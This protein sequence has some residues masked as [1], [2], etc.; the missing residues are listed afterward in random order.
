[1]QP[2]HLDRLTT[3]A[4]DLPTV[5]FATVSGAHL[6]GF[7]SPDSDVDL[8]AAFV[9][10]L[11]TRLGLRQPRETIDRTS[12][13]DG[14]ELDLV[15]HD[16]RKCVRLAVGGSGEVHEHILSPL[17]VVTTPWHDEL[18]ALVR[19]CASLALHRHYR[20][21]LASRRA[22]L[23]TPGATVKHLLYAYRAALSGIHV[24]RTGRIEANLP[25]LL[26]AAMAQNVPTEELRELIARK[27]SGAEKGALAAGEAARHLAT[28]D[29]LAAQLD[30]ARTTSPLPA[31]IDVRDPFDDF[32]VRIHEAQRADAMPPT[33]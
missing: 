20:G 9:R 27:R 3:L 25:T 8:R 29:G 7:E 21:F 17:I 1:V 30:A 28:L 18:Q 4:A 31:D 15:A 33:R 22:L 5:V 19:S 14:L 12:L 13:E 26:D 32:L 23:V 6:Y 10:P 16:V 24:L 11:R 2:P